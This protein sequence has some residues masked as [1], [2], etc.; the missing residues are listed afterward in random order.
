MK[1]SNKDIRKRRIAIVAAALMLAICVTAIAIRCASDAFEDAEIEQPADTGA[2]SKYETGSSDPISAGLDSPEP[3]TDTDFESDSLASE[4]PASISID[5]KSERASTHS[6]N[7]VSTPPTP[8][9][10]TSDSSP[11]KRWV[12]DTEQVWVVDK[13]AWTEQ[14][15]IYNTVEVSICNI[16]GADITGNASAHGK[17]HMKAGEGSG[18]HSEVR[19]EIVGYDTVSHKEE[20]H[21]ETKVVGGHWE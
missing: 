19:R 13:A 1:I 3:K 11:S 2:I 6:A 9:D 21:W 15:P 5:T 17:A 4:D 8:N 7:A 20:G 18:H 10:G 16:C 14:I 12:E